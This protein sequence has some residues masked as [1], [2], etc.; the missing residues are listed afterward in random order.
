MTVTGTVVQELTTV[1]PVTMRT[2]YSVTIQRPAACLIE[3]SHF[4][5]FAGAGLLSIQFG[6]RIKSKPSK[7]E[8]ETTARQAE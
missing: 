1:Y 2:G 4:Q 3:M 5:R 6:M 8:V 7:F